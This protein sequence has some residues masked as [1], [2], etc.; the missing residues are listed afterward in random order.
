M[1]GTRRGKR[2]IVG[3]VAVLGVFLM[4]ANAFGTNTAPTAANKAAASGRQ[5]VVAA[6][7]TNVEL[8]SVV[9]KTSKPED[10]ILQVTLECTIFT[11]LDTGGSTAPGATSTAFSH[12]SV[13]VWITVD[14]IIVPISDASM[15]PQDPANQGVGGDADKVT[16]CDREYQRTVTDG[17]NPLDGLDRTQDYIKTKSS[18]AFNWLRLNAGSGTHTIRVLANLTATAAGQGDTTAQALVGNRT[19]IVEPTKTAVN[20]VIS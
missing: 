5:V 14:G 9:M 6:P 15:P 20:A 2:W 8:L 10:L 17:E 1:A 3:T 11:Q 13:S 16:F 4:G 19:L 18:H 12:G 7:G